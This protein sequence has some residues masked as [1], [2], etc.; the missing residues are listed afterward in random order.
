MICPCKDCGHRMTA[1]HSECRAYKTWCE[2]H[3]EEVRRRNMESE[4]R[5]LSRENARKYWKNLKR[6]RSIAQR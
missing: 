1:C 2:A 5:Q 3:A 6:G 4:N